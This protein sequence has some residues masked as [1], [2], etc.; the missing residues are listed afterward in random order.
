MIDKATVTCHTVTDDAVTGEL[1]LYFLEDGPWPLEEREFEVLLKRIQ[2]TI[3]DAV[4]AAIDGGIAEVY[5]DTIG[6]RIRLQVDSPEGCPDRLQQL[7]INLDNYLNNSIEY[8]TAVKNS[9]YISGIRVVTG[10]SLGRFR[11]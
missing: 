8:G 3:L 1:V 4:D 7:I 5:P 2:D 9:N 10:H 11:N 6:K